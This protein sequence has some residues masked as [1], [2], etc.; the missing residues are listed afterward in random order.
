MF[1]NYFLQ[2]MYTLAGY[3]TSRKNA[4]FVYLRCVLPESRLEGGVNR[5][6]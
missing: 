6:I 2:V 5:Q 4:I 1:D 3:Y